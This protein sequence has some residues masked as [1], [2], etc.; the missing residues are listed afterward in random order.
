MSSRTIERIWK[1]WDTTPIEEKV[2]EMGSTVSNLRNNNNES[3]NKIEEQN[4]KKEEKEIMVDIPDLP[5][6][7]LELASAQQAEDV[8]VK[9]ESGGSIVF[10]IVGAGQGGGR[11]AESFYKLGYKKCLAV[12]TAQHD[13]DGLKEVPVDQKVLMNTGHVGGAGKI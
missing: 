5:L 1:K 2:R 7:E 3:E 8:S 11:L 6:E 10:G 4:I 9:D 12:N 13:L